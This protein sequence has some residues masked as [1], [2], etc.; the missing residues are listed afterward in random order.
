MMSPTLQHIP[1][2]VDYLQRRLVEE[3]PLV[4]HLG[5]EVESAHDG[6][7]ILRAP[8]EPNCNFKGTAFGG[9]LFCVAVLAGWSWVT[10][11]LAMRGLGA[12]AVIQESTIRY[13]AP[14]QGELRATLQ[15]PPGDE[16]DKFRKM[17]RRAGRGRIRLHVEMLGGHSPATEF[18]GVFVAIAR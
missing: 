13:L 10:R 6:G 9:S 7:V 15:A 8:F 1:F 12:D 2:G 5:I 4:K 17:L 14:V 18:V 16:A 3:F 11:D